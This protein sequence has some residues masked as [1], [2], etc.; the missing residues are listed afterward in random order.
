MLGTGQNRQTFQTNNVMSPT[1]LLIEDDD[2]DVFLF[3]DALS[4]LKFT[5][6][7][8]HASNGLEAIKK[9]NLM[10]PHKPDFIF[11]DL[12]MPVMMGL[13]FLA[14]MKKVKS[15]KDIPVFILSTSSHTSDKDDSLNAGAAGFFS[16][17]FGGEELKKIISSVIELSS[18][19]FE[20][21]KKPLDNKLQPLLSN[22]SDMMY[23]LEQIRSELIQAKWQIKLVEKNTGKIE[24]VINKWTDKLSETNSTVHAVQEEIK[25]FKGAA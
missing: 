17:P 16:K 23:R 21:S 4:D 25:I 13:Q 18:S 1:I 9:L 2:D 11:T 3:K 8:L 10:K 14:E 15:F 6:N 20:R 19:I 12:N 24:D 5:C 22:I 7:F